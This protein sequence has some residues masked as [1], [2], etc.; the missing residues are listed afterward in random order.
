MQLT[1]D[2]TY[3]FKKYL[4][5]VWNVVEVASGAWRVAHRRDE[6]T[7]ISSSANADT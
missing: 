1:L 7:R 6:D 4:Y 5:D 3:Y 2:K